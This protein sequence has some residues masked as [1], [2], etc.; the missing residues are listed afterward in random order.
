MS[1]SLLITVTL[2]VLLLLLLASGAL[3]A[4]SANYSMD[5][6]LLSAGGA[7]AASSS[8]HVSLNGSLGQTSIVSSSGSHASLWAGFWYRLKK[9]WADVFLPTILR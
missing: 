6:Q 2:L 9:A 1:K 8:G 7:P 3:A 4:S 5:W